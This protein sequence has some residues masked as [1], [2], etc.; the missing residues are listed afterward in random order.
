MTWEDA[1]RWCLRQPDLQQLAKDAYF[2]DPLE[3]AKRYHSS[4]EYA[5]VR[6]LLP[7]KPGRALDLGA[8]NGILSHALA[9]DG[10]RV[11]AVEPDPSG[12]V[13]AGAIRNMAARSGLPITVVEAFGEAIPLEDADFDVVVARQVLH[14]AHD[15]AA[16]CREM[17]RLVRSG[18]RVVTLR[19]HVVTGAAQLDAFFSIHPL[20]RLYGG[21][22]AFTL[23]A[24]RGALAAANL[25]IER[26]IGPFASVINFAPHTP[27]TLRQEIAA[28]TGPLAP[29]TSALLALPGGF[30][31]VLKLLDRFDNRPGRLVSFVCVKES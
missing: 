28:R 5:E 26:E 17:A 10:W 29:A 24:Y 18:G 13:G 4:P 8:G 16:F 9:E 30:E 20:H 21:E 31:L 19:D 2:G 11:T 25:R 1:V 22:N 27:Q 3:T 14:H 15:L 6:R 12:L 23:E 7:S